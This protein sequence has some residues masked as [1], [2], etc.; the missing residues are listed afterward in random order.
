MDCWQN[1]IIIVMQLCAISAIYSI[2]SVHKICTDVFAF[3]HKSQGSSPSVVLAVSPIG[4][5]EEAPSHS[6]C[7]GFQ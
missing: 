3:V 1:S 6:L 5:R 7:V 4:L 2:C